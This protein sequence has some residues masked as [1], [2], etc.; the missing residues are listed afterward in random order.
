MSLPF[1]VCA[2]NSKLQVIKMAQTGRHAWGQ[3]PTSEVTVQ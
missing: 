1:M 2:S 3:K